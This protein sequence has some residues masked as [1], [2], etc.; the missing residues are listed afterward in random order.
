MNSFLAGAAIV[1]ALCPLAVWAVRYAKRQRGGAVFMAG[2]MLVFG[3]N[4]QVTPPLPPQVEMV[5]KIEV[6]DEND[7][8][9][10]GA[11]R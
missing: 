3:M 11:A 2:L 8:P 4:I 7:E 1:I 9:K 5:R 6:E 10:D